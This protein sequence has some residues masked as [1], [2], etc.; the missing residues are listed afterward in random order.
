MKTARA[1]FVRCLLLVVNGSCGRIH[2]S[3]SSAD[4]GVG[5]A[6]TARVDTARVD[7]PRLSLDA[8]ECPA[9][10]LVAGAS[11]YRPVIDAMPQPT[12]LEAETLC[13]ADAVGAHL[14]VIDDA[15]EAQVVDALANIVDHYIGAS[16]LVN[17]GT[18][19]TVTGQALGYSVWLAGE[20]NGGTV[21]NCLVFD[22][23]V[24][25]LSDLICTD[26]DDYVCEY[27]GIP[28]VPAA[29]GQ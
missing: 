23:D 14:V 12:W 11:C 13:E 17:E 18:F 21:E 19:V 4:G 27:D 26:T 29:Y 24:R 28:A 5:I 7:A 15:T 2:F 1:R 9:G 6:D 3:Q 25:R 16:D 10:Y 22:S 8:G 20:P